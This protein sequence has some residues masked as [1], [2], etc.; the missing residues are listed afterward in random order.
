MG[1]VRIRQAEMSNYTM[2]G[3]RPTKETTH[4]HINISFSSFAAS[5]ELDA[6][7]HVCG[8]VGCL[9]AMCSV[10]YATSWNAKQNA[11]KFHRKYTEGP[12]NGPVCVFHETWFD[13]PT[14][15]S[16][17]TT[18]KVEILKGFGSKVVGVSSK[19]VS[20]WW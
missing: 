15:F 8:M 16:K 5:A 19:N 20:E 6:V 12:R 10:Q 7:M 17:S 18:K 13:W 14:N 1:A 3:K 11:K 2:R 4:M 9:L